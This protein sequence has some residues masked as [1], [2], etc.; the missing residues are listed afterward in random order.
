MKV[1]ENDSFYCMFVYCDVAD[2]SLVGDSSAQV[3]R[4]VP[5]KGSFMETITER[6]DIPH[7]VPV[8]RTHFESLQIAVG[9]DL[10]ATARFAT[11]KTLIKLHF[12]PARPY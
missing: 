5:I 4:S 8:L 11:G 10:E 12:R 3:L 9:T 7:Y 1:P 6:F 2:Y